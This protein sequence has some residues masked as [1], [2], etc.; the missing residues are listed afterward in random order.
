MLHSAPIYQ[1]ISLSIFAYR[2][3][4]LTLDLQEWLNQPTLWGLSVGQTAVIVILTGIL[5]LGWTFVR[6]I[7]QLT[8]T[9]FRI[10][11]ALL[12]CFIC[13]LVSFIVIY[14]FSAR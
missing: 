6:F 13:G 7:L 11:C 8:G 2:E 12:L 3:G 5:V 14:N 9:I 4:F 10:G 1:S